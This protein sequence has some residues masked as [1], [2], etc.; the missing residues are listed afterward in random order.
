MSRLSPCGP[1]AILTLVLL[2]TN[3]HAQELEPR[4]YTNTPVGLNFLL[5]G[6]AYSEGKIAFDPALSVSNGQ[7]R[8][9]TE[10]LAYSRALDVFGMSAKIAAFVPYSSFFGHAVESGKA[11]ERE[12]SGFNEPR[13]R[14][15]INFYGAPAL[16][17]KDFASYHQDLIIGASL[18]VTPPLGQYDDEKIVNLGNNHWSF[19]P[20]LGISK[21]LGPWTLELAP[22]AIFFTDNTD[23]FFGGTL[24]Q[25]PIYSVQGHILYSFPSGIWASLDGTF[26][27]GGRTT[28]NG[29]KSNNEQTSTRAGLTVALPVDRYN[30]L[31]LYAS[32][33]TSTRTGSEFKTVG[34]AWQYRWGGGY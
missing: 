7:F 17:V 32:T 15:S 18:Q 33:G 28:I 13:F 2:A 23:F 14:F 22:S 16:S 9:N 3:A 29:V 27:T 26:F 31:K 34:I 1:F 25:A 21:A 30:S 10:L 5:A 6:Y 19:K 24:S 4:E 8:T 20:E 11:I 12:M